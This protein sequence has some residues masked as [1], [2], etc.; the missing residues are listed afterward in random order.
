MSALKVFIHTNSQQM[1]GALAAKYS[2]F[3]NSAH[4]DRFDVEIINYDDYPILREMNGRQ[5][6]RKGQKATWHSE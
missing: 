6:L 1:V 2:F 5:Y 3:K 4:A